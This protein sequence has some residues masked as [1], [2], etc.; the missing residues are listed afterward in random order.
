MSE[1]KKICKF[2]NST[3]VNFL[4][5][6]KRFAL[7]DI[8]PDGVCPLV[9]HSVYPY[10]LTL[11]TGGWFNWVDYN[12][13]VI[14]NCPSP[15]GIA[16]YVKAPRG[17]LQD[18]IE[19][20]VMQQNDKC[21]MEYELRKVFRFNTSSK[22][23]LYLNF[24]YRIIPLIITRKNEL[25]SD[26]LVELS[27]NFEDEMG[28]C[29]VKYENERGG[30]GKKLCGKTA[31]ITGA[32]RGI[33]K[34]IAEIFSKYNMK[35]GLIAHSEEKLN[36]IAMS[37]NSA[38]SEALKLNVDL[39]DKEA[40]KEAVRE[41]KNKFGV[42]DFLINN[43]GIGIRG[44]W[45]EISLDSELDILSVNYTAPIILIRLVL[46]DMIK[47][48]RGH[49]INI[50]AIGGMYAAPYQGAYCASKAA[51]LSYSSSLAYELE[52]T[53]INISSIIT[54]PV[55]TDFLNK[56]NFESFKDSK[57]MV[58]P[59]V[60]AEKVLS[61]IEYPKEIVF[62]GSPLKL[63]AVKITN[64]YPSFFR[65]IIEKKNTPPKRHNG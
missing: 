15:N 27:Y 32:S 33:G 12:E 4:N 49:I 38:G 65:R 43:A 62:V 40:I 35:L 56:Q 18:F 55:D 30:M 11:S 45:D 17:K 8:L 14:V 47:A 7:K 42:P 21:Y 1:F 31:L 53:N 20:E 13:H 37:V 60:L 58:S 48:D 46:P 36:Q 16:M 10:M 52:K 54:G 25:G 50:N 5:G 3:N 26:E 57:D 22:D 9:F 28:Q 29:Q 64:F 34:A 24:L 41:F 23:M 63:L 2:C 19:I 51:L 6:D 61:A 44:F 59:E 39:R